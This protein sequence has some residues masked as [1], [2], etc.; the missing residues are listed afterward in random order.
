MLRKVKSRFTKCDLIRNKDNKVTKISF[1]GSR[2]DNYK[3]GDKI[4]L[5]VNI[6]NLSL[7]SLDYDRLTTNKDLTKPIISLG[8]KKIKNNY[9][10][11]TEDKLF[12]KNKYFIIKDIFNISK[13]KMILNVINNKDERYTIIIDKDDNSYVEMC[14]FIKYK[15]IILTFKNHAKTAYLFE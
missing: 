6:D 15:K 14:V 3:I 9:Y 7:Y 2:E 10:F 8:L 5:F 13:E 4:D 12:A 11:L 1:Y